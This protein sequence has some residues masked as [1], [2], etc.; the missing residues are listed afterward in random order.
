[1][2]N[3]RH[4]SA[5][6]TNDR[7]HARWVALVSCAARRL[8]HLA[9]GASY[10]GSCYFEIMASRYQCLSVGLLTISSYGRIASSELLPD[11]RS[12]PHLICSRAAG[13]MMRQV[14]MTTRNEPIRAISARY[15]QSDRPDK[16]R[17]LDEFKALIG[18]A[19]R[20]RRMRHVLGAGFTM[21]RSAR[22]SS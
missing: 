2:E 5:R 4:R 11:F 10:G 9:A 14:S 19:C 21:T 22:P 6:V 13:A 8:V 15:R 1:M 16:G 18:R 12:L 7:N 3:S 20:I 17:I